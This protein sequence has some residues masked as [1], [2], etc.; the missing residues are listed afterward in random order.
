MKTKWLLTL[1]L[2]AL[3]ACGPKSGIREI[4]TA[5]NLEADL[6]TIREADGPV[7]FRL[8]IRNETGDTLIPLQTYTYCGC[9]KVEADRTPV[10]PGADQRITVTYDPA[11]RPGRFM[12]EILVN[13]NDGKTVRSFIFKGEVIGMDHPVEEDHPYDFGGG[14]HLSHEVLHY[15]RREAGETG[16]I[17]FRYANGTDRPMDLAFLPEGDH[18]GAVRLRSPLHLDAGER[19]TLHVRFTMPEGIAPDDTLWIP[20]RVE[21]NGK[22]LDKAL[23]IKAIGKL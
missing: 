13:Y 9:T 8:V 6:G 23:R 5:D 20:I 12:E 1:L 2:A 22:I 18:T 15:G 17:F 7:T 10:P 14:L 21:A 4:R 11:Y 3:A 19:D 16:D